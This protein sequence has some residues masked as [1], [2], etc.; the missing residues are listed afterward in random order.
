M[1]IPPRIYTNGAYDVLGYMT[2]IWRWQK[3]WGVITKTK[4]PNVYEVGDEVSFPKYHLFWDKS[5]Q[6]KKG[7]V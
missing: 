6:F 7:S 5:P 1:I 3:L 2:G 4:Y